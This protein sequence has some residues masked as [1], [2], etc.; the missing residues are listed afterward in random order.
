[1]CKMLGAIIAWRVA[2]KHFLS[3]FYSRGDPISM[4][5]KMSKLYETPKCDIWNETSVF[6]LISYRKLSLILKS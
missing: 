3:H 1:M 5:M 4:L 6:I 2:L